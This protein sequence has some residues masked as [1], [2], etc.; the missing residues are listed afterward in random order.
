MI[1]SVYVAGASKKL[2]RAKHWMDELEKTGIRVTHDWT[3][4][5]E[6]YGS[7]GAELSLAEKWFFARADLRGID[8]AHVVWLL[9]PP[10]EATSIGMWIEFGYALNTVG[11]KILVSPPVSDRCIFSTLAQV[12]EFASDDEAFAFIQGYSG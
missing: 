9:A 4:A 8:E 10:V 5:V 6:K 2:E 7:C 1:P 11:K 3:K 12:L